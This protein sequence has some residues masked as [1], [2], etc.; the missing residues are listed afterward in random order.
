MAGVMQTLAQTGTLYH[1]LIVV[2]GGSGLL[3]SCAKANLYDAGT[4]VPLVMS[5]EPFGVAGA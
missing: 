5:A 2:A 3:F 1:T 4:R